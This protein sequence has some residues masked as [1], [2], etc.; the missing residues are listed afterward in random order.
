LPEHVGS[1]Y[2]DCSDAVSRASFQDDAGEL[3]I[4][5]IYILFDFLLKTQYQ[6]LLLKMMPASYFLFLFYFYFIFYSDAVSRASLQDDD[7]DHET[8]KSSG[9]PFW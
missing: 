2:H 3:F 1:E 5:H 8:K 7:G 9:V 4:L 6:E